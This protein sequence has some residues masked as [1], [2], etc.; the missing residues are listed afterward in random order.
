MHRF[1]QCIR[2]FCFLFGYLWVALPTNAQLLWEI[3]GNGLMQPSYLYGTMHVNDERVYRASERAMPF[4]EQCEVFA[5]ELKFDQGMNMEMMSHLFMPGDTTL[6]DLLSKE[7]YAF[8]KPLLDEKLGIMASFTE[9]MKPIFVSVLMSDTDMLQSD[10]LPI[11]LHF[12]EVAKEKGIQVVGLE[13]F[14]E[15]L[16]AFNSIPLQLQADML[17]EELQ[18][19]ADEDGNP[20]DDLIELYVTEN[21]DSLYTMT[22]ETY[23]EELG[24]VLLIQRNQKMAERI[25]KM[26]PN[27]RV[28]IGVGA[29]HLPGTEGVVA[30]LR[31]QGFTVSP[32]KK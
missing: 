25:A 17:Y 32:I 4:F 23:G 28:F 14:D 20:T 3:S 30:L 27:Q 2:I 19:A 8:V 5:G 22:F 21:L 29:A 7:Q 24:D 9:R 26:L 11:D 31:L 12:Q 18:N 15:Q 13:T 1:L 10:K 6:S 16:A